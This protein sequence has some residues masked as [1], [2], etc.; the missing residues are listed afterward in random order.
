[1]QMH[2]VSMLGHCPPAPAPSVCTD[3]E[4][5]YIPCTG[6]TIPGFPQHAVAVKYATEHRCGVVVRGAGLCDAISGTDPLRDNLPLQVRR[7]LPGVCF[8]A[9]V[10]VWIRTQCQDVGQTLACN[11]TSGRRTDC[12]S[13]WRVHIAASGRVVWAMHDAV[14]LQQFLAADQLTANATW[15]SPPCTSPH[16]RELHT[17]VQVLSLNTYSPQVAKPL[18]GSPE[19]AHTAAVVNELSDALRAA[20]AAHPVNARRVAEGK[21]PANV[22]LLR[23]CGSR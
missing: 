20:L 11:E 2:A 23:G 16:P 10:S 22:M 1:M 15:P 4:P 8:R 13:T 18:D 17:L 5:P 14:E 21:G 12:G 7:P 9:S 19:A 6:I 3:H